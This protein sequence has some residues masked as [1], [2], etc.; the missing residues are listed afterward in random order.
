MEGRPGCFVPLPAFSPG[1]DLVILLDAPPEV[2]QSRT[3]EVAHREVER[4]RAAYLQLAR[5][6]L[7]RSW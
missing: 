3:Q 4:Q 6:S 1:P 7:L 5:A 2:L